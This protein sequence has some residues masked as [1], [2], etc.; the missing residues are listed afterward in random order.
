M[1]TVWQQ[2]IYEYLWL[3]EGRMQQCRVLCKLHNHHVHNYVPPARRNSVSI[4]CRPTQI[5]LSIWILTMVFAQSLLM[6]SASTRTLPSLCGRKPTSCRN[7]S[8]FLNDGTNFSH[9]SRIAADSY[10]HS[11]MFSESKFRDP[12]KVTTPLKLGII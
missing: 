10:G 9:L 1:V 7:I 8:A 2:K 3:I 12:P 6:R 5:T 4:N 11:F